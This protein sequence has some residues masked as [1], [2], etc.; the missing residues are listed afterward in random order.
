[1]VKRGR[2]RA[3]CLIWATKLN[4]PLTETKQNKSERQNASATAQWAAA[5]V[6]NK[7]LKLCWVSC[8]RF[9]YFFIFYFRF[10]QNYIFVFEIYRNIPRPP[11]CRAAGTWPPRCRAEG[12]NLQKK[13]KTNCGQVPGNRPPG[14]RAAGL[15]G[16]PAGGR[17]APHPYIRVLA[18]PP[19]HLPC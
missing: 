7:N 15:P 10:L 8:G 5:C 18:A 4:G 13:R 3:S 2:S 1:M 11:R 16:R 17:P 12:A 19:P 6:M 14:T 9:F